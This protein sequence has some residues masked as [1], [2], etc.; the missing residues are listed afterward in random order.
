V[1]GKNL[2]KWTLDYTVQSG[3]GYGRFIFDVDCSWGYA[4]F[5]KSIVVVSSWSIGNMQSNFDMWARKGLT[6]EVFEERKIQAGCVG[7]QCSDPNTVWS[8]V[9]CENET[10]LNEN[11]YCKCQ[12]DYT[13]K[14][15][16]CVKSNMS[17]MG[18]GEP[19]KPPFTP[20]Q[21]LMGVGVVTTLLV[22]GALFMG[23]GKNVEPV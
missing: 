9:D 5:I 12:T 14:N 8:S 17:A 13:F 7:P 18:E 20:I 22:S 21:I 19:I 10:P 11:C 1:E 23:G 4:E 2:S 6:A 3:M 15:G 16:V